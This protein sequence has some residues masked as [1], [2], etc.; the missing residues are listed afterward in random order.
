MKR[1]G[2]A[3]KQFKSKF[4]VKLRQ[5]PEEK[6]KD[7]E[8]EIEEQKRFR[9]QYICKIKI[10]IQTTRNTGFLTHCSKT[11]LGKFS[12]KFFCKSSPFLTFP[13]TNLCS[14]PCSITCNSSSSPSTP[15]FPP[16]VSSKFQKK[17]ILSP[18]ATTDSINCKISEMSNNGKIFIG[19]FSC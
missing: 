1:L 11:M 8:R 2:I 15:S 9:D 17:D 14:P 19:F 12:N 3:E 6:K 10:N 16:A 18:I 13:L 5:D 4:N 7:K